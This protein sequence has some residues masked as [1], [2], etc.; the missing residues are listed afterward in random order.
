MAIPAQIKFV[1]VP[2]TPNNNC[3]AVNILDLNGNA[4]TPGDYLLDGPLNVTANDGGGVVGLTVDEAQIIACAVGNGTATVTIAG[5]EAGVGVSGTLVATV[6]TVSSHF[7]TVW[8]S[9]TITLG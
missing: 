3:A 1:H 2:T 6:S 7:Q 5:T 8:S 4:P 9:G